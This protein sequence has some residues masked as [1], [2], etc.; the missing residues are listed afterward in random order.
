MFSLRRYEL[1]DSGLALLVIQGVGEI[2]RAARCSA[3]LFSTDAKTS[4]VDFV[5]SKREMYRG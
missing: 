1:S 4:V 5:S 2:N 3:I